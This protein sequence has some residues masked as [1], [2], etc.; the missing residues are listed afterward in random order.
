MFGSAILDVAIGIVFIYIVLSLMCST[1]REG[2]EAW[3]K[4]RAAYLERGIRELL[5]DVD[6]GNLTRRLYQHP[7]IDPLYFGA[8]PAAPLAINP[9]WYSRGHN[10]PS[11][12]PSRNFAL[13]LLDMAARGPVQTGQVD[14]GPP[15]SDN[16]ELSLASIRSGIQA[17]PNATL[18]RVV[19]M[20]V[21]TAGDDLEKTVRHV[22]AWYDSAMERISGMY[23]RASQLVIF[24]LGLGLAI[25]FNI[26]TLALA[27]FLYGN[28]SVREA[29]VAEAKMTSSGSTPGS[30]D[31]I[32]QLIAKTSLPIGWAQ[33]DNGE[34]LSKAGPAPYVWHTFVAPALGWLLTAFAVTLGAPFWFDVLNKIMTLRS[35][36]KP[37]PSGAQGSSLVGVV[38]LDIVPATPPPETVAS[39]P[40]IVTAPVVATAHEAEDVQLDGCG[41]SPLSPTLDQE[42][43]PAQGGVAQ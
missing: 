33:P 28:P 17:L 27:D 35:S 37:A 29:L 13:A 5:S 24:L 14:A 40:V 1:I 18:Q 21:N 11:Y 2:I 36:I 9:R 3:L 26:N 32:Q 31:P 10:L 19:S 7:L 38:P 41:A 4:T 42:L 20:A 39:T 34:T 6:T 23:K 8:F 16:I 22:E 12:I 43:P 25:G 15:L 30:L